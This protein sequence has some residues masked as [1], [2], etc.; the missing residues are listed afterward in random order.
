MAL[1]IKLL[2]QRSKVIKCQ[3]REFVHLILKNLF[4]MLYKERLF[5]NFPIINLVLLFKIWK[6]HKQRHVI[7]LIMDLVGKQCVYILKSSKCL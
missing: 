1:L 2:I 7:I 6:Y 4:V 5:I 3:R